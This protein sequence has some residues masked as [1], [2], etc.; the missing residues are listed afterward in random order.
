MCQAIP[1]Q[2]Y[3]M[4][5]F[6]DSRDPKKIFPNGLPAQTIQKLYSYNAYSQ[7]NVQYLC[8]LHKE[9]SCGMGGRNSLERVKTCWRKWR[10]RR[11]GGE[12]G[13]RGGGEE[14][15]EGC[16]ELGEG[17]NELER[18]MQRRLPV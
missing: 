14:G 10:G 13:R 15:E 12:E 2:Q 18:G 4:P 8:G 17:G 6:Q 1:P 16:N 5:G 9:K 11:G 3:S 7:R